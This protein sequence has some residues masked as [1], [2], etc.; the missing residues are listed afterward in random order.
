MQEKAK[1]FIKTRRSVIDFLFTDEY[2]SI[3]IEQRI[4]KYIYA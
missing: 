2:G 1:S 3:K 4:K